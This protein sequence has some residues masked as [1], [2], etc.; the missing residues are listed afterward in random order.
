M[1]RPLVFTLRDEDGRQHKFSIP[2]RECVELSESVLILGDAFFRKWLV[3]HDL[4]DLDNKRI[5]L[6]A[7]NPAYQLATASGISASSA[8]RAIKSQE[9][10]PSASTWV[11]KLPATRWGGYHARPRL[12]KAG[13]SIA[14]GGGEV[15][16]GVRGRGVV[17]NLDRKNPIKEGGQEGVLYTVSLGIGTPPQQIDVIFDT[18]SYMLA[19][20]AARL[21]EVRACMRQLCNRTRDQS[22]ALF[23][24][25]P[26][27]TVPLSVLDMLAACTSVEGP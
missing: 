20:F 11:A 18:G 21:R 5:G 26:S 2:Y 27:L 15:G 13:D 3:L 25:F 12:F 17:G 14:N 4:S 23:A 9:G 16:L 24:S 7:I 8:N 22:Q 1:K 6:A 10:G 19:V